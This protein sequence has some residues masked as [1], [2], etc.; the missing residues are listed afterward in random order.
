M[1]IGQVAEILTM[2]VL[3]VTLK[4]L[5]W[6]TTMIIGILGYTVRFAVYAF[7][8]EHMGLIILVNVLHGIVLRVLLRDGLHLRRRVLPEGR[9]RQRAGAVQPDDPRASA[10]SSPTRSARC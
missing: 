6:R 10:R 3:G 4:S 8:P 5:G 7:L 2:A 9:P 1:S